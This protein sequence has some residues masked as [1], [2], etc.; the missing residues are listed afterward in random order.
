MGETGTK[1]TK[2]N[3]KRILTLLLVL[4]MLVGMIGCN[5]TGAPSQD[6][7]ESERDS[8]SRT[9][10]ESGTEAE[11]DAPLPPLQI[12]KDGKSEYV[13]VFS[14]DASA[15]VITAANKL[16]DAIRSYTG[17]SVKCREDFLGHSGS[18]ATYEILL[19]QTNRS[20]SATAMEGLLSGEYVIA[21]EGTKLV[22]GGMTERATTNAVT[23][24]INDFLKR[25]DE[26][27]AG[28]KDGTL[29]FSA[30]DA[31]HI[32]INFTVKSFTVNGTPLRDIK[33]VY[34]TDCAAERGVAK[35]IARHLRIY[36]GHLVDVVTEDEYDGDCAILV[37]KTRHSTLTPPNGKFLC[38]VTDAGVEIVSD[39]QFGYAEAYF[40]LL[41]TL[42]GATGDEIA[43]KT[44]DRTDGSDNRPND[45][46]KLGDLRVMYHNIWG[47]L[48][49]SERSYLGDRNGFAKAIYTEYQP[50]VL[51]MQESWTAYI[52]ADKLLFPW[53]KKTYGSLPSQGKNH[54]Y[55]NKT[56]VELIESGYL[57]V[58]SSDNGST[59]AVF[60]H[61]ATNE[62]FG[63]INVHFPSNFGLENNPEAANE[64]RVRDAQTSVQA[65]E[66]I[67]QK[68]PDIPIIHG[69]D[70]NTR[71]GTQPFLVL[72]GAG[73]T[74][75]RLLTEDRTDVGTCFKGPTYFDDDDTFEFRLQ[76]TSKV[77][78][79]IDHISL[80][81][82]AVTVNRY[83]VLGDLLALTAS[84]H[85]AHFVDIS[86]A[87]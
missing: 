46:A 6:P 45:L 69:G 25:S 77:E 43:L 18:P 86:F 80:G 47:T 17:A 84:D 50:D 36:T 3:L 4:G 63:V 87:N 38:E 26:L 66:S 82:K 76:N 44:G 81:G 75:A 57:K 23:R 74:N 67:L 60:K 61:L 58:N 7:E 19:G 35:L 48:N 40:A 1:G 28:C 53:L 64:R 24:F 79:A 59:W 15:D 31:L 65:M 20:E 30:E 78:H 29:L 22:I 62:I 85:V 9:E 68:Y 27:Y 51:C 73:L 52:S 12:V 42:F 71:A 56:T 72:N 11:T 14:E 70:Y 33:I 37:G 10:T 54:I 32:T 34:P 83:H 39:A 13:I 2:M 55:Y 49:D 5:G 8:E 41:D 16:K 21:P